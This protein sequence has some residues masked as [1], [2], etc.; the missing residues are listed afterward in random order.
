M[1]RWKRY[2][3]IVSTK[4]SSSVRCLNCGR[5][6][7]SEFELFCNDAGH[8]T[9]LCGYMNVLILIG[10]YKWEQSLVKAKA[11]KP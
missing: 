1:E 10:D 9:C 3:R 7:R 8:H 11:K 2:K 4:H 5:I 6:L